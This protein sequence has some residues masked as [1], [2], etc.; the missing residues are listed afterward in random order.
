M[1]LKSRAQ[2]AWLKEHKPALFKEFAA[3]TPKGTKL[4]KHVKLAT[5]KKPKKK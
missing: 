3:A 4:P 1:P 5:P 2:A